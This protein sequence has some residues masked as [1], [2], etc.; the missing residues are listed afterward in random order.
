MAVLILTDAPAV[1]SGVVARLVGAAQA[2]PG[3]IEA[4]V[5]GPE[6][7]TA[8]TD[9]AGLAG[10]TQVGHCQ[11]DSPVPVESWMVGVVALLQQQ[12]PS[13]VLMAADSFGRDLMPR[14]AASLDLN[15]VSEVQAILASDHFVRPAYAGSVQQQVRLTDT[16]CLLTLRPM[17]FAP[18][19]SQSA[20]DCQALS[21]FM[22]PT[23]SRVLSHQPLESG[24]PDLG[25]ARVVIGA[26]RG[27]ETVEQFAL[28]ERLA[29]NLE[30]AIG[31]SRSLVDAGLLA[32][33]LQI[34]QTGRIIA[35]QLYIAIGISGATQ[36]LAGIKEAGTIVAIN[37]D[38]D[39]PLMQMADYSLNG[40]LNDIL[41]Q[42]IAATEK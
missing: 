28:V 7:A 22:E 33:E 9:L 19:Q 36:H 6:A 24:R 32:N 2:L 35:P 26:G 30:A 15:M 8:A 23:D 13:H 4:I 21:L 10:V 1:N 40:D 41:P 42:L 16:P 3:P 20:V 29:D 18:A 37:V 14:L 39:A 11:C 25:Q 34:G 12:Q 31:G 5:L 27:I 38:A 17:G